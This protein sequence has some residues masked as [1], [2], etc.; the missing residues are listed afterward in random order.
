[1]MK[2]IFVQVTVACLV[3]A[4]MISMVSAQGHDDH[5]GHGAHAPAAKSPSAAV[6][7]AADMFTGLAAAA[8][9]LVAGFIY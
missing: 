2:K 9:S 5:E 8:V 6:I 7:V 1:M 4:L 3:L